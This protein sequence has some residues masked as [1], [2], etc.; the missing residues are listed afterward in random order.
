MTWLWLKK[1]L[2][3]IGSN[4]AQFAVALGWEKARVYGLY[5]GATKQIPQKYLTKAAEYLRMDLRKLMALNNGED[6]SNNTDI[7]TVKTPEK[8]NLIKEKREALGLSQ[9]ILGEKIGCSQQHI[10]RIEN[11]GEITPHNILALHKV[12]NIPI[13]DLISGD[14]LEIINSLSTLKK[15]STSAQDLL[16]IVYTS[17]ITLND[18]IKSKNKKYDSEEL[19][20][21]LA[22]ICVKVREA[23]PHERKVYAK[24]VVA[25]VCDDIKIAG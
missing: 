4:S 7:L 22:Q 3:E 9:A 2:K 20:Q 1:R 23:S 10:Q 24:G 16:D 15:E 13:Y 18:F 5:S 11:G 25:A 19:A 6:E 17:Y 8:I 12:L 21:K 14:L